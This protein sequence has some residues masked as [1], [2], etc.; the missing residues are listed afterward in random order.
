MLTLAIEISNPSAFPGAM[1]SLGV[2]LGVPEEGRVLGVRPIDASAKGERVLMPA[3]AALCAEHGVAA[4]DLERVAVSVGP[5]GFTGIRLAVATAMGIAMPRGI[6]CVAVPTAWALARRAGCRCVVALSSKGE[7]CFVQSFDA[8]GVPMGEAGVMGVEAAPWDG[9]AGAVMIADGHLP[10]AWRVRA[11]ERGVEVRPP[12]FDAVAVLGCVPGRAV[13]S[14]DRLRP[15]Y[16][17]E[18]E[19]VTKWNARKR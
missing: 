9:W 5:G 14:A 7:S 12:E 16:A 19:A 4:G 6:G 17:R 15:I 3:I 13:V 1:G 8:A 10:G 11:G 18:P 2:A